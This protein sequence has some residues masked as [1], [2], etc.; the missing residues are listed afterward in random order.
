MSTRIVV[1]AI[2]ITVVAGLLALLVVGLVEKNP[3]AIAIGDRAKS[4]E[5]TDLETES[6]ASLETYR[7]NWV[8]VNFWSSWC[9]PCRVES[10]DLQAFQDSHADEGVIVVGVNLEDT[11]DDA[12]A[13]VEEFALTYPQL[14]AAN[15]TDTMDAFGIT[16][17]P[18]NYLIDPGG[19]IA[20]IWRGPVTDKILRERVEPLLDARAPAAP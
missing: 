8:L 18:E 7:G 11:E 5:L 20:F 4:P 10:P 2:A 1:F 6:D 12:R 19:D 13:F 16:A 17:R 9:D 3:D 14:R 15:N